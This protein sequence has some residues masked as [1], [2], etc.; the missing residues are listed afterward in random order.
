[1]KEETRVEGPWEHGEFLS[2][3]GNKNAV[4]A[5][6]IRDNDTLSLVRNGDLNM[7]HLRAADYYKVRCVEQKVLEEVDLDLPKKRH[8]WIYGPPNCGKTTWRKKNI[9]EDDY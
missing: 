9:L 8:Y 6:A 1:M 5:E 2:L 7:L 3:K 4:I